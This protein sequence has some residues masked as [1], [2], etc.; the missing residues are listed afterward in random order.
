MS[1]ILLIISI[2]SILALIIGLKR[3]NKILITISILIIISMI[4]LFFLIDRAVK[5]T[6]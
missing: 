5:Y 4:I 6:M 2:I 3:R 1:I